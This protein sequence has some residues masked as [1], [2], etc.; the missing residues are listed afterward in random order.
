MVA[1]SSE[2]LDTEGLD[3]KI[4]SSRHR[5]RD[6]V[7]VIA[8][9]AA[10]ATATIVGL[11]YQS[12]ELDNETSRWSAR[13]DTTT[14]AG[15]RSIGKLVAA[16]SVSVRELADNASLRLYLWALINSGAISTDVPAA[17][18]DYL[19]SLLVANTDSS[20]LSPARNSFQTLALLDDQLSTVL[21]TPGAAT[22][23][24]ALQIARQ[25]IE[26][27]TRQMVLSRDASGQTFLYM[28]IIVEPPP[29]A[30]GNQTIGGVLVSATRAANFLQPLIAALPGYFEN[31]ANLL[32]ATSGDPVVALTGSQDTVGINKTITLGFSIT[33][34]ASGTRILQSAQKVPG[35]GWKLVRRIDASL[36]LR[37]LQQRVLAYSIALALSAFLLATLLYAWR[38]HSIRLLERNEML[39]MIIGNRQQNS[40]PATREEQMLNKLVASLVNIIDLHDPYSA[41]HSA[42]LAELCRAIGTEMG[43]D[44]ASLSNLVTAAMLANVGKISLPRELLTKRDE[45]SDYEQE[46]LHSHVEEGVEILRKLDLD[47]PILVAISQKQE[48]LDGKGYPEGLQADR[49]TLPGKILSVANAYVALISPRAYRD[50]LSSD[51]A[52]KQIGC[53]VGAIYDQQSF[54]ALEIVIESGEGLSDW[55]FD[56]TA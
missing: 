20:T 56:G 2:G 15:A 1:S 38:E 17:E 32:I 4:T 27:R 30:A 19:R 41:F 54:D 9:L 29:G 10:A 21:T 5:L 18:F 46:I 50:A 53:E 8:V 7:L 34:S 55:D 51:E 26:T 36:A 28:A 24:K 37:A 47:D 11:S 3:P 6:L 22:S 39:P 33:E 52:L 23:E 16:Q 42:R 44:Q 14:L 45:L 12:A 35:T 48:R 49:I 25:A 40:G 13:L 43:L 31:D